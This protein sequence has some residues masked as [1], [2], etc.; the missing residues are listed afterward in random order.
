LLILGNAACVCIAIDFDDKACGLAHEIRE[1]RSKALLSAKLE[2]VETATAEDCP[3]A[4]LGQGRIATELAG[5]SDAAVI[6]LVACFQ[7]LSFPP[8]RGGPLPLPRGERI[9]TSAISGASSA[10]MPIT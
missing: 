2:A 10:F 5:A 9:Y 6:V 3:E 8:L 1:I 4:L 7:T